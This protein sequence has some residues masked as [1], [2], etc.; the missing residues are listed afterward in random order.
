[1]GHWIWNR[2]SYF[3]TGTLPVLCAKLSEGK[4]LQPSSFSVS[5][6]LI[7]VPRIPEGGISR[8]AQEVCHSLATCSIWPTLILYEGKRE[9]GTSSTAISFILRSV[10]ATIFGFHRPRWSKILWTR[11]PPSTHPELPHRWPRMSQVL[12]DANYSCS[13]VRNGASFGSQVIVFLTPM[14]LSSTN[15]YKIMNPSSL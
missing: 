4:I 3:Y 6:P 1:M 9:H 12:V 15:L 7:S 5:V 2:S 8:L 11:S 14:L 10:V 13:T